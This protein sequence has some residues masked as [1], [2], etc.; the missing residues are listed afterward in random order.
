MIDTSKIQQQPENVGKLQLR[1][2]V[3]R[4]NSKSGMKDF[5]Y[6]S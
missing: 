6:E 4:P 3:L 1:R 2:A 5:P